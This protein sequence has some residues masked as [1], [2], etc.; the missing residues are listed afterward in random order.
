MAAEIRKTNTNE[1]NRSKAR[2]NGPYF[3]RGTTS[4]PGYEKETTVTPPNKKREKS[5]MPS[6]QKAAMRRMQ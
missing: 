1:E 3:G 2:G 4:S 6:L 5:K